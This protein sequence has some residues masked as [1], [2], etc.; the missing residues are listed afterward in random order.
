[1]TRTLSLTTMVTMVVATLVATTASA[2]AAEDEL[3][4]HYVLEDDPFD[5]SAVCT[6]GWD[7]SLDGPCDILFFE[8]TNT[9][10]AFIFRFTQGTLN[11]GPG[12]TTSTLNLRFGFNDPDGNG[13]MAQ[14]GVGADGGQSSVSFGGDASPPSGIEWTVDQSADT[15]TATFPLDSLEGAEPGSA[16]EVT[17]IS[18]RWTHAGVLFFTNMDTISDAPEI[19]ILS[20]G[21]ELVEE[22][23]EGDTLA[24]NVT[25]SE[26]TN[27]TYVYHWTHTLSGP[28]QATYNVTLTNNGSVTLTVLDDANET[29]LNATVTESQNQSVVLENVTPGNWTVTVVFIDAAGN[30]SFEL[31]PYIAPVE[32]TPAPMM[33]PGANETAPADNATGLNETEADGGLGIPGL[34]APIAAAA[35]ALAFGVVARRRSSK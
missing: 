25:L 31:A 27:A 1:M 5:E 23:V 13:Y 29:L 6:N 7:A 18:T 2:Q 28:L 21:P 32:P 33:D 4:F 3:E 11:F 15:V 30:F 20:T 14:V 19:E 26:A 16:L 10:D 8:A 24:A 34:Q 12:G 9:A 35:L 22:A 17:H